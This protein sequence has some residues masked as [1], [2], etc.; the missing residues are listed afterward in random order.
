ML[1]NAAR[2]PR[3]RALGL[4]LALW[5][6]G[7]LLFAAPVVVLCCRADGSSAL[8]SRMFGRCEPMAGRRSS[9]PTEAGFTCEHDAC[10]SC[11]DVPA[12]VAGANSG[13]PREAG[14][15]SRRAVTAAAVA[16]SMSGLPVAHRRAEGIPSIPA[17][18]DHR[19]VSLRAVILLV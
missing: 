16:V 1:A 17:P 7:M 11:V 8:E 4:G 13:P 3:L 2:T 9:A 6:S 14:D 19:L 10:G 5:A 18:P 12:I 15:A